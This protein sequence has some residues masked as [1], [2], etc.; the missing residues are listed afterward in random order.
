[1]KNLIHPLM[2]DFHPKYSG[3]SHKI[4]EGVVSHYLNFFILNSFSLQV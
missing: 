2:K 3:R 1:M 4:V